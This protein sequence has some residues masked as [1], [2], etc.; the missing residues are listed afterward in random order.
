M[1]SC[2]DWVGD[3]AARWQWHWWGGGE[4]GVPGPMY[5]WRGVTG[6][7]DILVMY[8]PTRWVGAGLGGGQYR[9]MMQCTALSTD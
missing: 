6:R 3:A 9:T 5:W 7:I 8:L 4:V 1:E 2:P